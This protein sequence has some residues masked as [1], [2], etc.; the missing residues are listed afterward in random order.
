MPC[1][2]AIHPPSASVFLGRPSL[3]VCV[4]QRAQKK[5]KKKKSQSGDS[6]GLAAQL[7]KGKGLK[8]LRLD[9]QKAL[10]FFDKAIRCGKPTDE[11]LKLRATALAMSKKSAP[12]PVRRTISKPARLVAYYMNWFASVPSTNRR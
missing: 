11:L 10:V 8:A 12:V 7:L 5:A 2:R 3:C 6:R 4:L 1:E 9:P